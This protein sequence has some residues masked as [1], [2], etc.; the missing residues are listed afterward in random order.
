LRAWSGLAAGLLL[1][2]YG[3]TPPAGA[4]PADPN[5]PV[6]LNYIYGFNDRQPQTWINQNLYVVLW[7]GVLWLAFWFP[8]HRLLR[9]LFAAPRPL[10]MVKPAIRF[11]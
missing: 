3:F 5:T 6:N 2:C 11:L 9:R 10:L 4:H 1:V 8:T 7:W